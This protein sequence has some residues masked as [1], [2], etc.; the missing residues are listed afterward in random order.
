MQ[1]ILPY[2][3]F[4]LRG[5][6]VTLEVTGL[7]MLLAIPTAF[8]LAL[9][10]SSTRRSVRWSAGAFIEVFRGTSALVQLFWAFYVLPFFGIDLSPLLA[11]VIVLGLNEGSYASE[12][13]RAGLQSVRVGQSEAAIALHLPRSYR[14]FRVILPQA[15]P[16][17]I[18]PFGNS[19]INMLKF[20]SLV[21]LVTIQDLTYRAGTI[22]STV[23]ESGP[24][25]GLTL[26]LYFA[27]ALL[28]ALAIREL[29]RRV[30][31]WAGR[32]PVRATA[33]KRGRTS[34]VPAWALGR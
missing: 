18:P 32:E 30:N 23:G 13:V 4:L 10:R 11:G 14:F 15:L 19:L 7:A 28:V 31:R 6:P 16:V 9:G 21:S 22:R 27:M 34:S 25:Y 20:T 24:I 5:I 12:V 2:L 17:L 29:E 33:T 8:V 26:L 1:P 3:P